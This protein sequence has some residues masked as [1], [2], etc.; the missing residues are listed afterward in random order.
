MPR[1]KPAKPEASEKD[2]FRVSQSK[3]KTYRRCRQAYHFRY[4]EK[5][6]AKRK[7]RALTF[8]T[9]IHSMIERH[10][11]G[12][13]PMEVLTEMDPE[14]LKL[15]AAEKAEYGELITD[16]GHIMQ[17]YFAHWEADPKPL[18]PV[19]I[20]GKSAE[21]SFD[22]EVLPDVIF[23]GKID[24]LGKRE[25]LRW[26]VE[27]KTFKRKPTDDDRWRNLQSVTYFNAMDILGWP[28]VDGTCWDYIWSKAPLTPGLLQD[29]KLSSKSIDTLPPAVEDAIRRH[30]L[31]R[32]DYLPLIQKAAL[33]RP[34]WFTRIYTTVNQEVKDYVFSEFIETVKEMVE[35]HGKKKDMNIE[36][37]CSW[38]DYEPLCRARLQGLDYDFIKERQ[39]EKSEG[40]QL[41]EADHTHSLEE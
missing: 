29:G 18:R 36:R 8:G 27:H 30:G 25:G 4:V 33:N 7:S 15:F 5:L 39:Y 31:K 34:K 38:C 3:V 32:N 17:E 23:N 20:A 24:M 12:D 40:H 11:E 41:E 28:S 35:N 19:R 37:H 2:V 14:K 10:A 26:L 9:L 21:H 1:K 22:I 16:A 13:D 6:R